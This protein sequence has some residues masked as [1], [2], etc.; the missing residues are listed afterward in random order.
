MALQLDTG[1]TYAFPAFADGIRRVLR[2]WGAERFNYLINMAG[3]SRSGLF[4]EVTEE[5][6][7]AA[8]RVHAKG[9]FF[10]TQTLL[11]LI[12]EDGRIANISFG[13]MRFA[14]PGRIAYAA[15]KGAVEVMT[16]LHGQGTW[17][18]SYCRQHR[19]AGRDPDGFLRGHG[20]G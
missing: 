6:F 7:D 13:L 3:T 15:M 8:Y 2:E 11:P 16:Y 14:Y 5:D 19:R 9:P 18:L 1:D 4:C 17:I 12:A 10:L 20:Q